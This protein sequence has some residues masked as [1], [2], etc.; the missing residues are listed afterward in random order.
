MK[1]TMV[2]Y[3]KVVQELV[4]KWFSDFKHRPSYTV[5]KG[6]IRTVISLIVI[7]AA[8]TIS[9]EAMKAV[10]WFVEDGEEN[11]MLHLAIVLA[12]TY[13]SSEDIRITLMFGIAYMIVKLTVLR[14]LPRDTSTK[15]R[16]NK[17]EQATAY[18]TLNQNM[19]F[20]SSA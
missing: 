4:P 10:Q 8:R 13:N 18:H 14:K 2:M 1:V 15:Q 7:F 19:E 16:V 17:G 5:V 20:Y 6:F 3:G 11:T 9:D 12:I